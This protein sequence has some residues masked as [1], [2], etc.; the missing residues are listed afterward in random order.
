MDQS[1]TLS[2]GA[3]ADL[4]ILG[5]DIT[6]NDL[7]AG[8]YYVSVQDANGCFQ[9]LEVNISD[10]DV[11]ELDA[12]ITDVQCFGMINGA[13]DL[14][15]SGGNDPFLIEWTGPNSFASTD[16]DISDLGPGDYS[17]VVTDTLGCVSTETYNIGEPGELI[18][19]ANITDISCNGNNNGAIDLINFGGTAAFTINWSGPN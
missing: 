7:P 3:D 15:I 13:I 10:S 19:D 6:I 9:I 1:L 16:E 2:F 17:V 4:N 12:S 11:A 14:E 8:L 5:T 18:L